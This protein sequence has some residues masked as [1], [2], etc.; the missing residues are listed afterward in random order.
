M[1]TTYVPKL[2]V[3]KSI[4]DV[5]TLIRYCPE[6]LSH[7]KGSIMPAGITRKTSVLLFF[8]VALIAPR[9]NDAFLTVFPAKSM[10]D[11]QSTQGKR[12]SVSNTN[13]ITCARSSAQDDHDEYLAVRPSISGASSRRCAL[14]WLA[15][16]TMGGTAATSL[17]AWADVSDG[18]ALPKEA[19]QFA[20]VIKLKSNIKVRWLLVVVVGVQRLFGN[21]LMNRSPCLA[22]FCAF[23]TLSVS[24]L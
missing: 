17:P 5:L 13:I 11:R 23:L 20:N 4:I 6:V 1:Q 21:S 16:S 12:S 9:P 14:G 24:L 22:H 15:L 10:V 18:N 3:G 2:F 8:L 19:Q 7:I